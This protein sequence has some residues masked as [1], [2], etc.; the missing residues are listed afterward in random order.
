MK[1]KEA[2]E[3]ILHANGDITAADVDPLPVF[4]LRKNGVF[5]LVFL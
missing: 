1:I 3:I 5:L 2:E 4:T